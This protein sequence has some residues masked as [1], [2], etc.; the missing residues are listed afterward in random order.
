VAG[1]EAA[2]EASV[3]WSPDSAA[4]GFVSA[5]RL[6]LAS[7]D[8]SPPHD[9]MEVRNFLG[10]SWRGTRDDG[11][12]LLALDGKLKTLD[13]RTGK[14]R[15]LPLAFKAGSPPSDPVFLPEG[16]GFV[17]LQDAAGGKRL[18]RSALSSSAADPLFLT[19]YGVQFAKH[20]STGKWHVFY[21]AGERELQS[22][23]ILRT[24]PIDPKTGLL[25]S[26]PLRLLQG[27]STRPSEWVAARFSVGGRGVLSWR[28][29]SGSLPIWRLAWTD[30]TGD[31]L[32]RIS[33]NHNYVSLAL[34]P[35]ESKIAVQ[36]DDPDSHIWIL[37]S[38]TGLGGRLSASPEPES[39][40]YWAPDGKSLLYVAR[41][42]GAVEIRRSFLDNA[43]KPE[44]LWRSESPGE[45][46]LVLSGISPDGRYLLVQRRRNLLDRL[47]LKST[48]P[49]KM[50]FLAERSGD[51]WLS[52]D[53]RSLAWGATPE[54]LTL[55][56]YP[57][58]AEPVKR[59][60]RGSE[61][62]E[63]PFFSAG[64]RGLYARFQGNLVM[65]PLSPD[66]SLGEPRFLRPWLTTT[67]TGAVG[68]VASR[69]GKR[70]LLIETDQV[71]ILNP[72]VLTDWTTLLPK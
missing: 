35:D 40:P 41:T 29:S 60:A 23:R 34:S 31:L 20:P 9:L 5:G 67:R 51:V 36:V 58:T 13:L 43:S 25:L 72:Q 59:F 45:L 61:V 47:D 71:E 39:S 10:A 62:V 17:F 22:S 50:E 52:P 4:F 64:G 49:R 48:P 15:D 3:F 11:A 7:L 63:K 21:L 65:F 68:G 37:D 1:T 66:R 32:A 16:D 6:R 12:I 18:F 38:K 70:L 42:A 44:V 30:L 46:A 24:A 69:D 26:A 14:V 57:V 33:E 54:G 53:G 19:N 28:Y 2:D 55:Q 56:T 27:V 8:G